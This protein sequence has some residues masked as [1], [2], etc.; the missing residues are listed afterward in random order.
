MQTFAFV[1]LEH[2]G[3]FTDTF[4]SRSAPTD[5]KKAT[6]DIAQAFMV[7]GLDAL[8]AFEDTLPYDVSG[9]VIPK[10]VTLSAVRMY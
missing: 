3:T 7:T 5:I 9:N 6:A 1:V 10:S 8:K 4:L 2:D